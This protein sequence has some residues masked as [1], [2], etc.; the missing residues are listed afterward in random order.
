MAKLRRSARK[1]V[2]SSSDH[3]DDDSPDPQEDG[4]QQAAAKSVLG[5]GKLP[6]VRNRKPENDQKTTQARGTAAS[7]QSKTTKKLPTISTNKPIY[8]FFN[9][10]VTQRQ[11]LSQPSASPKKGVTSRD[12]LEIIQDGSDDEDVVPEIGLPT[13]TQGSSTALA[14]RKRK[15][16]LTQDAGAVS[17]SVPSASLKFRKT[18]DGGRLPTPAPAVRSDERPW[19]DRFGPLD[20]SELAVHKRKVADVRQ[21]FEHALTAKRQKVLILKGPAGTGKTTTVK[22]LAKELG[23]SL[24]EWRNPV[25]SD[26]DAGDAPT[27]AAQFDDFVGRAGRSATLS[28]FGDV[29]NGSIQQS[30]PAPSGQS[31][32][33]DQALL[34]EEFPSTFSRASN[35]LHSFRSAILQFLASNLPKHARAVPI[36]MIISETSVSSSTAAADSFTAHRLLGPELNSHPFVNMIEFNPVAPTIL[37]KALELVVIKESRISGRRKTP[38]LPVLQRLAETGDIRSAVCSLEFLCLRGD[39]GDTWSSKV[40]FTKTKKPKAQSL[41]QAEEQA[42]KLISNRESS[43]GIFHSVGKVIYNKRVQSAVKQEP[44]PEWCSQHHRLSIP[45]TDP[46]ELYN[47]LGTDVT[48][49]LAA[50]HEN[51]AL[52]CCCASAE[53]SLDCMEHCLEHLSDADLLSLDHFSYGARASSGSATDN[54][55]QDE[56]CFQV[57]VRG[58]LF[59]LPNPVH[60]GSLPGSRP[61]D[62]HKMLYPASLRLWRKQ[63]E[64]ADRLKFV[65]DQMCATG[66]KLEI[67]SRN[68]GI[69]DAH[70]GVENWRNNAFGSAQSTAIEDKHKADTEI[71]VI[72]DQKIELLLDRLPYM[73]RILQSREL[74]PH[75]RSLLSTINLITHPSGSALQPLLETLPDDEAPNETDG[76]AAP[77]IT[78][79]GTGSRFSSSIQSSLAK[80]SGLAST[81]TQNAAQT[82]VAEMS[83]KNLV[84]EDDDIVDDYD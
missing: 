74:A 33:G 80:G 51:Y 72:A 10:A 39:E 36:V 77:R 26:S 52:S 73:S 66:G 7:P 32:D 1:L 67:A 2:V 11:R 3:D 40:T 81:R 15:S 6:S 5:K 22:L 44:L 30:T 17:E 55:R 58:L 45:E 19:M 13:S 57:S 27:Q 60:R 20:V 53:Q 4:S 24:L 41:T 75:S 76:I 71:R 50:L 42:L 47:D 18:S 29:V 12:E 46:D 23:V 37:V 25:A 34:I 82:D 21:W 43:L 68:A 69:S 78:T 49:F 79:A 9:N 70:H 84:L 35:A 8:S 61:G 63:E 16:P 62:S 14:M 48:T 28:L 65:S 83:I 56:L 54:L 64:T 59:S 38:G 31:R